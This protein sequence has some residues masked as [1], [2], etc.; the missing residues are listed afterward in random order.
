[1]AAL[2]RVW[3]VALTE[4]ATALRSRRALV[5][6][7]LFLAG[8]LL[9]MNGTISA[10]EKIEGELV[11]ILGLPD[12]S[13]TGAVS[14]TL[15][16]SDKFVRIVRQ[17]TGG[18][19]VFD[20][21][22]GRNPIELVYAWFVFGIA[23]FLTVLVSSPRVAE[24]VRTGAARYQLLRV[25]RTEWSLGMFFGEALM[26][27]AAFA[28]AALGAWATVSVRI[29]PSL[30]LS[31]LPGLL[32]W[33]ARVWVY[34]FAWLGLA[35]GVSHLMR[36]GGKATALCIVLMVAL[37]VYA[38]LA[39]R[40]LHPMLDLIAP[41]AYETALWRRTPAAFLSGAAHLVILGFL[42]LAAGAAVFRRR[43]I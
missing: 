32:D 28:L 16:K 20:D 4:W 9:A 42:Y 7:L 12:S 11:D 41:E 21:I 29:S 35:V 33:S 22:L 8:A 3:A 24:S 17:L 2:R 34:A 37:P 23:P 19:L 30:G 26:L 14:M 13:E 27:A 31:L 15:W 1:M 43:D 10:F 39:P 5:I 6:M 18:G 40:H 38:F 25:T 36:S